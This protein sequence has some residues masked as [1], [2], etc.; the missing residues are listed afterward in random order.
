MDNAVKDNE[1]SIIFSHV[2]KSYGKTEVI[3]DLNLEIKR[4]ER[5]ILLGPSGCGKTTTLRMIAGFEEISGGQLFMGGRVVNDVAPGERN[6]AMVFQSYALFPHM[7]VWENIT[8]GLQLQKLPP[9]EIESRARQAMEILH[10]AGYENKKTH[11]LSGGQKQRVALCRA[12]VK[13]SPYFL[14]DEPLSNLDAK[15]RQRAR[16]ELVKL[17][18]MF[19]P[20]MVYVTHDQIEAM[21]V[22]HRIAVM[23]QGCIQQIDTPYNIYHHPANTFVAGFIGSPAMNILPADV[24]NG[25]LIAGQCAVRLPQDKLELIGPRNKVLFGLRPEACQARF[26]SGMI[27]GKADFV[28]NTGNL[29]TAALHLADGSVFYL[30]CSD[31]GVDLQAV[32]GFDFAWENVCLFDADTGINL[33]LGGK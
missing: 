29:K 23:H 14:L 24:L 6:I 10:L 30:Q 1:Y 9:R 3:K 19:K 8:F 11:E 17:H 5:L 2:N 20:T 16:T 4:G 13:Q 12:L 25:M 26:D 33:E 31:P 27:N 28:E 32:R 18:E 21:T 7:T 15:L 22:A